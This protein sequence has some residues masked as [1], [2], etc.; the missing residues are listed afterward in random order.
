MGPPST[1]LAPCSLQAHGPV[2]LQNLVQVSGLGRAAGRMHR[3]RRKRRTM[4]LMSSFCC[5]SLWARELPP[6]HGSRL[7]H[8]SLTNGACHGVLQPLRGSTKI[9]VWE[10][11]I[12]SRPKQSMNRQ[13]LLCDLRPPAFP[14]WAALENLPP[15]FQFSLSQLGHQ[16]SR[17]S[18]QA[19]LTAAPPGI[20]KAR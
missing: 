20:P 15:M 2:C 13:L 4:P 14:L 1:N 8:F 18:S 16:R 3:G 11:W 19:Q 17:F 6:T 7:S 5:Q 12:G 10:C 9:P